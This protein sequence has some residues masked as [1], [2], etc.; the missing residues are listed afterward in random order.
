MACRGRWLGEKPCDQSSKDEDWAYSK[1]LPT[2][3]SVHLIDIL[4]SITA[5]LGCDHHSDGHEER[6]Q[7]AG[8][9]LMSPQGHGFISAEQDEKR[10]SKPTQ[11]P[12][13]SGPRNTGQEFTEEHGTCEHDYQHNFP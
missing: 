8:R 1:H 9:G 10:T 5:V 13:N 3:P 6:R 7:G 4:L 12:G 11:I 2:H